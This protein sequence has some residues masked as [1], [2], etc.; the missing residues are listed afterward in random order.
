MNDKL[1]KTVHNLAYNDREYQIDLLTDS[2]SDGSGL[3]SYHI[4]DIT[5]VSDGVYIG[6]IILKTD[7][8]EQPSIAQ[9]EQDAW[10]EIDGATDE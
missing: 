8:P 7:K 5:D 10:D 9:L 4:F 6:E 3:W 1:N 2:C